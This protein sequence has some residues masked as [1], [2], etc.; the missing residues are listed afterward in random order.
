[1]TNVYLSIG[2]PKTGATAIQTFLRENQNISEN[3]G[4]G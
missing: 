4:L 2:M 1:M 3:K